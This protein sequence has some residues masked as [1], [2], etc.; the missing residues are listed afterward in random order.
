MS[1][2]LDLERDPENPELISAAFRSMHTLKGGAGF[3][4]LTAI[5]DIAHKAEDLLGKIKEGKLRFSHDI[6]EALL[7][8]VDFIKDAI[9]FYE[10]E[11]DVS[12]PK[13]LINRLLELQ[14][15]KPQDLD[16]EE[17]VSLEGLLDKYGLSYLK[18]R[19]A[20][21]ILEELSYYHQ[22]KDIR[23]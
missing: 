22:G 23:R 7:R 19:S 5:V 16:K 13:D 14:G 4:G 12:A 3:L 17:A 15:E 2:L 6:S 20:E 18:G 9:K 1:K 11:E 10:D 21:D 8:T